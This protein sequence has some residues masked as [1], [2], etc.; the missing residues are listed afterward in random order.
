MN[1]HAHIYIHTYIHIHTH[2]LI[3]AHVYKQH[4]HIFALLTTVVGGKAGSCDTVQPHR[5][6]YS[7]HFQSGVMTLC[8]NV[9]VSNKING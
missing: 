2:T 7:V 3:H 4:A 1:T 6:K 9:T 8:N 5:T